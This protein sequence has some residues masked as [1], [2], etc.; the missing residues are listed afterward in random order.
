MFNY[1]GKITMIQAE[2]DELFQIVIDKFLQKSLLEPNSVCFIANSKPVDPHQTVESQMSDID[3]QNNIITILVNSIWKENED[4]EK[5]ITPLK[6]IIC[7]KCK[8]PC[9]F[10]I[11][12][13]KIKLLDCVNN[14]ITDGIKFRDFYKTQE[15]N[16]LI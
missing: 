1:K 11:E 5:V 13:H 2:L 15:I 8:E 12:N 4:K 6:D 7:P 9:R 3:K 16:N 14:H 10:K